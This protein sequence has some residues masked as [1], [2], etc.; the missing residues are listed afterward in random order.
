M[1]AAAQQGG[2]D[3]AAAGR[4]AEVLRSNPGVEVVIGGRVVSGDEAAAAVEQQAR[5]QQQAAAAQPG[6]TLPDPASLSS[7]PPPAVVLAS[8]QPPYVDVAEIGEP[9]PIVT[10][11]NRLIAERTGGVDQAGILAAELQRQVSDPAV[12]DR[13]AANL[14]DMD[15]FTREHGLPPL[16]YLSAETFG[17]F[18]GGVVSVPVRAEDTPQMVAL[19]QLQLTAAAVG[20]GGRLTVEEQ[21]AFVERWR[22]AAGDGL[23][24]YEADGTR[25]SLTAEEFGALQREG[26]TVLD[27]RG[28]WQPRMV[29]DLRRMLADT[30]P[31]RVAVSAPRMTDK[32]RVAAGRGEAAQ[33]L[34]DFYRIQANAGIGLVN[35]TLQLLSMQPDTRNV[36]QL[37]SLGLQS[38]YF[39][40]ERG[41]IVQ[42]GATIGAGVIM[43]ARWVSGGCNT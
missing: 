1:Q 13:A 20:R 29:E 43:G 11:A 18:D 22:D 17:R 38:E 14:V 5:Q 28:E 33:Q 15:A 32:E 37:P 26:R 10:G 36:V 23:Y 19:R 34:A 8:G 31:E 42:A 41:E 7:P 40:G 30:E 6:T 4:A 21:Q 25:R 3:T 2:A 39:R 9:P 27:L 35:G 24:H 12:T 16:P